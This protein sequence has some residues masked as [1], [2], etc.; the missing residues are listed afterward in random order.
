M[1]VEDKELVNIRY[2]H[3]ICTMLYVGYFLVVT[4]CI[5]STVVGIH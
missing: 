5:Y 1:R 3:V 2:N 4:E